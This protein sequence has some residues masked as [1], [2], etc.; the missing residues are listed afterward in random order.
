[1]AHN[2]RPAVAVTGLGAT[3]PLGGDAASTW[4][5]LLAGQSGAR[6]FDLSEACGQAL[7]TRIAA[8]AAVDPTGQLT[9]AT[10][11]H[12]D[13]SA[14]LALVA[15]REAWADAHSTAGASPAAEDSLR[16]AVV[17]GVGLGG[18]TSQFAQYALL[19]KQGPGRVDPHCIPKIL[20]NHAAAQ[21]GLLIGARATAHAPVSACASGAEALAHAAALIRS[22]QADIVLAGG[23]DA[24]LHPLV[25][26]GFARMRALSRRND[27]PQL[28]SRPFDNDR[29]GF[30]LAEGAALLVLENADR[31]AQRGARVYCHLAG[32]AIT[33]DSHHVAQPEPHG[34]GVIRAVAAALADASVTPHDLRH[35]NA[36]AT[37]TPLGDL[38][39]AQALRTA[40]GSATDHMPVSA[41][42]AALGHTLGA[43]GAIE[44]VITALSL[45]DRT[46]PPN[47]TLEKPDPR[48]D[49]DLVGP[50]PRALPDGP[51]AAL[52][53]SLGFGGHN[54]ALVLT[55]P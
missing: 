34:E 13:R 28:A 53:T 15:A 14:Q 11:S 5:A 54:V 52:S 4:R 24:A 22:G 23:T 27:A 40:L 50:L 37:S 35:I 29:D 1:M 25:V 21:I 39:E 47:C 7:P 26:A 51:L 55:T 17:V 10:V 36:H 16:T 48:I 3:T 46:A 33:N 2:R 12:T 31:A 45:C 20:P 8:P 49:L 19:Q 30:V 18:V 42:K 6:H 9:P 43:A 44:A 41:P 32:T 38:T